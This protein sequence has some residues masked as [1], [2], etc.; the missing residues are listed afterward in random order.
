MTLEIA[1][2]EPL[3]DPASDAADLARRAAAGESAAFD[4]LVELHWPSLVRLAR[5]VTAS[6]LD[7]E[8]LAQEALARAWARL[9]T[10]RRPES[11]LPWLRRMLIRDAVRAARRRRRGAGDDLARA[12]ELPAPHTP[13]MARLEVERALAALTPRQRAIFFLCEVDGLSTAEAAAALGVAAA[14]VRVHRLLAQRRLRD[15]SSSRPEVPR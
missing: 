2:S 3:P 1:L 5:I 9:G 10:L 14:T 4:R 12:A 13:P 15:R 7:A 11:F 8:D 6:E